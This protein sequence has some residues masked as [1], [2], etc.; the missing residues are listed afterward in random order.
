MPEPPDAFPD[1][2]FENID[3]FLLEMEQH[4]KMIK[5]GVMVIGD[6]SD[7]ALVWEWGN[8]R[9][10]KPG[11]KTVIGTNPNGEMVWLSSQAPFGYIRINEPFFHRIIEDELAKLEFNQPSAVAITREIEKGAK[12]ISKGIADVIR[13]AAPI[14]SGLLRRS[15]VPIDPNDPI[16]DRETDEFQTLDL[17]EE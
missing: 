16:L 11:P 7:Y 1:I 14:D 10:K 15:I 4:D 12:R 6:A 2:T 13:E 5:A 3:A 17:S 8:T 9:Q